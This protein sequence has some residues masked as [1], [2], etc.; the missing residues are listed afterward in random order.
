MKNL[1]AILAALLMSLT[2]AA[3][4][5]GPMED[6]GEDVDKAVQDAGNAVEDVCEDVKDSVDADNPNC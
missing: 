5:D 1:T 3:C 6:F 2:L 4:D